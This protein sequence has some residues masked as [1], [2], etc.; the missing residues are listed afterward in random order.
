MVLFNKYLIVVVLVMNAMFV[1]VEGAFHSQT[2][3]LAAI[4]AAIDSCVIAQF[5]LLS[6]LTSP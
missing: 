1:L 6:L 4:L 3:T 2:E 5:A